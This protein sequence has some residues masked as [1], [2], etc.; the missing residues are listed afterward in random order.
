MSSILDNTNESVASLKDELRKEYIRGE[1]AR[2][3]SIGLSS[4]LEMTG[5]EPEALRALTTDAPV[6]WQ[7]FINEMAREWEQALEDRQ[8]LSVAYARLFLGPFEILAM[9]YASF[10]LEPNQRLMGDISIWVAEQYAEAGLKPGTGT[11]EVPDH[12]ALEWEFF[13]YL[14]HQYVNTQSTTWLEKRNSFLE[15]HMRRWIPVFCNAIQKASIHPFYDSAA[16]LMLG[17]I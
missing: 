3:V 16:R 14:T 13:Y 8:K 11:R 7:S 10:Y 9:P 5:E 1:L 2:I 6:A 12:A 4:P 17:I 15:L